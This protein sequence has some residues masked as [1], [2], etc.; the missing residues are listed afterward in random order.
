MPQSFASARCVLNRYSQDMVLGRTRATSTSERIFAIA[1]I[2]LVG[3]SLFAIPQGG[4]VPAKRLTCTA[5]VSTYRPLSYHIVTIYVTTTPDAHVS[6]TVTSGKSS[7]SMVPTAPANATGRAWLYQKI[8]AVSIS[9]I[10][11]VNVRVSLNGSVGH[12]YTQFKPVVYT[13]G[14]Y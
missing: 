1:A 11:H 14:S 4:A 7:W 9:T 5:H 8:S 10:N 13:P 2:L 6:G 3:I 12:C